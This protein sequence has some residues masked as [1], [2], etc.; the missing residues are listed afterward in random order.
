MKG[1]KVSRDDVQGVI[2]DGAAVGLEYGLSRL[3]GG[4]AKKLS[5][6]IGKTLS[7][8]SRSAKVPTVMGKYPARPG[9]VAGR[10]ATD[11]EQRFA[12]AEL[13]QVFKNI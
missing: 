5:P 8:S 3:T 7:K 13:G 12:K 2:H 10:V 6:G 11:L 4:L 9:N 1:E